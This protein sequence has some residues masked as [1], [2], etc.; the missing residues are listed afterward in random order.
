MPVRRPDPP[1]V[2]YVAYVIWGSLLAGVLIMAGVAA[3]LGPGIREN[4]WE[5]MPKA[6]PIS[7]ALTN[8]VLLALSRFLPR[9]LKEDL[10]TLTKNVIATAICEA[11][12][13][14]AVVAWML[15]GS[16]HAKIG[17][18][19]GMG[20]IA[21]CYPNDAR[22]RALGG[23]VEADLPRSGPPADDRSGG[24]GFGGGI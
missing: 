12:A 14:F 3:F 4:Q 7:A 1:S 10:P 5:P 13:L 15:T 23:L 18:I 19:L 20:G 8:V 17:M 9:L 21:I 6:F 11:G 22:W 2:R 16:E 24:T